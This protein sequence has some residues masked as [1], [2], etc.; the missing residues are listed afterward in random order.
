MDSFFWWSGVGAWAVLSSLGV[1]IAVTYL[2]EQSIR[3]FGFYSTIMQFA[4]DRARARAKRNT[5][6]SAEGG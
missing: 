1:V 3:Y 6:S 5:Q 2:A 4:W